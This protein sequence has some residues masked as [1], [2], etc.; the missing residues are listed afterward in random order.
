MIQTIECKYDAGDKP[1]V[2][3]QVLHEPS[4]PDAT[5]AIVRFD[6]PRP[7]KKP[8]AHY[9]RCRGRSNLSSRPILDRRNER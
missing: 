9:F 6:D 3:L 8:N 4:G 5:W 2:E 7:N 1:F